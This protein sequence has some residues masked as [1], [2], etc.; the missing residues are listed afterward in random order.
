MLPSL[1]QYP[2]SPLLSC[3]SSPFVKIRFDRSARITCPHHG[4]AHPNRASSTAPPAPPPRPTPVP[5]RR[6][7][8]PAAAA[9]AR[10]AWDHGE[11]S[12][13][14]RSAGS[15][16]NVTLRSSCRYTAPH[17][18]S[19]ALGLAHRTAERL[20]TRTLPQRSPAVAHH[21]AGVVAHERCDSAPG[22]G[23]HGGTLRKMNL[24]K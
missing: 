12:R 2:S 3:R 14:A 5:G 19:H 4:S 15:G 1:L 10:R 9:S 23:Y 13:A 21:S 24:R 20:T 11:R 18:S 16:G 6:A 17:S 7:A 8:G 22:S